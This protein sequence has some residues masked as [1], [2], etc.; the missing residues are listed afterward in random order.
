MVRW[1][2][3]DTVVNRTVYEFCRFCFS[4]SKLCLTLI[5]WTV[6]HHAPLSSTL[7]RSLLKFMSIDLV[8]PSNHLI[9]CHPLSF[10]PQSFPASGSFPMSWLFAS[11]G[12]SIGTSASASVLQ[13]WFPLGWTGLISLSKGLLKSLLQ[14]KLWTFYI[15]QLS[16]LYMTTGKTV[17]LIIQTFVS[18][19]MSLFFNTLSRFA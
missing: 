7:S 14:H 19:V 16:H 10:C 3:W 12:Q 2:G 9:L 1:L 5:S 6:P 17:A 11:G 15:V 18:K 13:G 4:V 8:V